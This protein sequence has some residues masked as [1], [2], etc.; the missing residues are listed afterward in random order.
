L[1]PLIQSKKKFAVWL[2]VN[3]EARVEK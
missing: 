3:N 1:R 2:R